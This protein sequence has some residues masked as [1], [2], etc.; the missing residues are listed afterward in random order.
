MSKKE[1]AASMNMIEK[2]AKA[3]YE[4]HASRSNTLGPSWD[5]AGKHFNTFWHDLAR[6]AI[7]AMREP[8]DAVILSANPS[9]LPCAAW[10]KMIDAAL[11]EK[12]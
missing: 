12:P 11:N 9:D 4:E 6:A 3:M 10:A 8:T 2:V 5:E 1:G 7:E